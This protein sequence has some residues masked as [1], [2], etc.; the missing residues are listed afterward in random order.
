MAGDLVPAFNRLGFVSIFA[1]TLPK[2]MRSYFLLLLTTI[3]SCTM[4]EKEKEGSLTDTEIHVHDP[5]SY[6]RPEEARMHHLS[7]D[8]KVDFNKKILEG[9]AKIHFNLYNTS[10]RIILD[11]RDLN[12]T[13]I[14]L[15]DTDEEAKYTLEKA[16]QF[17]GQAL[18]IDVP[19][20]TGSVSITY[21]TSPGAQALQWLAPEQ[22]AGREAPFLFTQSQAILARTWVPVQD[23]P[24]IRFTYEARIS[25]PPGLMA[26]MSAKNPQQKNPEGKYSFRMDQPIPAYL[27]ALAA[28][29]FDFKAFDSRTGVYAEPVTLEKAAYEF[30]ELPRMLEAAEKLYGPYVWEQYDVIVLPPSFPFGGMENPRITFATP[31]ILAGDR[32]LT[33]LIAHELAHSWSGNLVTNATWNDFW[34]NEGFTVYFE[35]RIMEA[36]YGK[37]FAEMQ[38]LLGVE[39][40]KET[41]AELGEGSPDTHLKLKLD[42]RD[43]DDG[44]NDVA[45]E[46]GRLLLL[47]MERTFGRERFDAFLRK[48]FSDHAFK[49]ITT[50]YF[51]EE[52]Y[53]DLVGNDSASAKSIDID[54]WI[55]GPGI[56]DNAPQVRSIRFESVAKQV[57][58]WKSGVNAASLETQNYTTNEWLRFLGLIPRKLSHQQMDELDETFRFSKSGNSE[59]LFA[60]LE[61]AILN[62]Y[63]KNYPELKDF[64][65]GIG[66]RKFVRPLFMALVKTEEGKKFAREIYSISRPNYHY[67]T[68]ATVDAILRDK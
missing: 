41:I 40:L 23:S 25:V 34:L 58:N 8:L 17:L 16:D 61:L 64:L 57:E 68:Q 26:V 7:L 22:T 32:S 5:H 19:E 55:Y 38:T 54:R 44:M 47:L 30:A 13:R 60:W 18:I 15:G 62:D 21:S 31:T 49:T 45:Y 51:I 12:I 28:G 59:I 37:D 56:P 29:D 4:K 9:K 36:L 1:L 14:T 2:I 46:K 39:D 20:N 33:A 66:R 67:V 10:S 43:P 63:K 65:T 6:S 42:G 50:E 11:T 48:H 53:R 24:G 52:Y 3:I 27:L 35:N